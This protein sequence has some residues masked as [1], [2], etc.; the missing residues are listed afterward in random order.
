MPSRKVTLLLAAGVIALG[1]V[2]ALQSLMNPEATPEKKAAVQSTEVIV[3]ARDLPTGT[4]LKESDLKWAPWVATADT[5]FLLVKG[6]ATIP[7]FVGAVV[8]DGFRANDPI[9]ASRI[10]HSRDQ[11][12]LAAVLTPGMR[13]MSISLSPNAQVAGFIFPGDR[14]DVILTHSFSRK[15]I[16]AM[17]ERRISETILQN[18]RVLALDQR[19]DNQSNDPKVAQLATLEVSKKDAEKLAMAIDMA[20]TKGGGKASLMLALRSLA[21]EET[22]EGGVKITEE[23]KQTPTWDSDVSR[24]YPSVN[25]DDGLIH[26]VQ[27]MRGKTT[28]ENTFERQR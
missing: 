15:D 28:T 19:S 21:V 11:G 23:D 5:S 13:A 16:P 1:T 24:S 20:D 25:G 8:R 18:I 10:A 2:F 9:T 4:V 14:V 26:R 6:K 7:S 12:F 22:T 27:V 3:A 17:T